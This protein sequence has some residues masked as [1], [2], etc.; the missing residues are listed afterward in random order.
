MFKSRCPPDSSYSPQG[1]S[2]QGVHAW[3]CSHPAKLWFYCFY[4]QLRESHV[5]QHYV[6]PTVRTSD[7][8]CDDSENLYVQTA[9]SPQKEARLDIVGLA[10]N[11]HPASQIYGSLLGVHSPHPSQFLH[12]VLQL[13]CGT[14]WATRR[15]ASPA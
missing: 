11:Q 10:R 12:D 7:R 4:L 9:L 14:V 15:V 1:T 5:L 3:T 6:V 13:I 2:C 8:S